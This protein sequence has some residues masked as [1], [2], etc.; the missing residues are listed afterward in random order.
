MARIHAP[1]GLG[2]R[3]GGRGGDGNLFSYHPGRI[4]MYGSADEYYSDPYATRPSDNPRLNNGAEATAMGGKHQGPYA[5]QRGRA[6][7]NL[8]NYHPGR[9]H[10]YGSA[11]EYYSAPYATRPSDDR[12]LGIGGLARRPLEKHLKC[13]CNDV[14]EY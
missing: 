14:M 8:F 3:R 11:D 12:R 9:I 6:D 7:E 4:H 1:V 2:A 5:G 13:V 10:M